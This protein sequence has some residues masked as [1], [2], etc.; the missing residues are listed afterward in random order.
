MKLSFLEILACPKCGVRLELSV[1]SRDETEIFEGILKCTCGKT[2]LIEGGIPRFVPTDDY[3]RSFSFQWRKHWQTQLDSN[4]RRESEE[5]FLLSTGFTREAL[6]GKRVLDVGCGMGRFADVANRLGAEVV[7]VDLSYAI[8]SAQANIGSRS[9]IHFA[10]ANLFQLP[11]SKKTFDYIFSIGVLHHTADCQEAVLG[12]IPFLKEGGH[13]AVWVY[14]KYKLDTMCRYSPDR[15]AA[16]PGELPYVLQSP[17]QVSS[18][19]M[20]IVARSAIWMDRLNNLWN[21]TLRAVGRRFPVKILYGF[22]HVAIPLYH[23]LKLRPFTPLR[24]IFKISMHPDPEWRVLDTFDNLSPRYQ[25]RHTYE[26]VRC[27]FEK[28]GLKE[29]VLLPN[30]IAVRGKR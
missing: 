8:E 5:T 9:N 17:F 23:V 28:G 27:W 22:C 2:F 19:W 1:G 3:V 15:F 24:L 18:R 10:Q 29:I 12:L 25:S 21:G 16:K 30:Q 11:F 4:S 14:P 20:P 26:E 13:L 6:A 7:G